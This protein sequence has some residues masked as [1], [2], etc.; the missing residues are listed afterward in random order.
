MMAFWLEQGEYLLMIVSKY[1]HDL[2][3]QEGIG[4]DPSRVAA[5]P[6]SGQ[7]PGARK[8]SGKDLV[9]PRE[10]AAASPSGMM[11]ISALRRNN[12][13]PIA[14]KQAQGTKFP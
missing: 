1:G 9:F 10:T 8:R 14:K 12:T 2:L 6:V 7:P 13:P 11:V 5:G 3:P 4:L